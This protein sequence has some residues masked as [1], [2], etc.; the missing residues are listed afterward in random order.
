MLCSI[1]LDSRLASI[2]SAILIIDNNNAKNG[3]FF[4]LIAHFWSGN[5][6]AYLVLLYKW[7]LRKISMSREM[8]GWGLVY[9][10][11]LLFLKSKSVNCEKVSKSM[12][13]DRGIVC[14]L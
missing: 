5:A 7:K 4:F 10:Y 9:Y 8:V 3:G 13:C 1:L 6:C 14:N 11:Y 2:H 12:I